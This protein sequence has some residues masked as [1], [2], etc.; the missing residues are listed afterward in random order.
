MNFETTETSALLE[1]RTAIGE[2]LNNEGADL[3]ALEAE[4]RAINDELEKRR[5]TADKKA[6]IRKAVAAGEGE[7]IM[8]EEKSKMEN[9]EIRN[10]PAYI[11]AYANYIKTGKDAECRA[12]LSTN[13]TDVSASLTGYVPVPD[14]VDP[15]IRTAWEKSGVMAL[16]TTTNLKGNVKVGFELSADGAVVHK[17]GTSAPSEEVITLGIVNMVPQSIKKWITVSDEALDLSGAD[18][19][20][21]IY[22]E[23]TYRIAKKAEEELIGIIAALPDTATSSSVSAAT[24]SG[25]PALTTISAA[26]GQVVG[27]N[28]TVV[29]NR[30]SWAKFK[31]AQYA[32]NFSIDIFEGL[33]VVFSDALPSYDKAV[34]DD[35]G[36]VYAIVG[37]FREGAQANYPNGQGIG[38]KVDDT[39]LAEKD[40]VKFVGRMFV[41]LGAVADKRFCLLTAPTTP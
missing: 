12:L 24:I 4:V 40:L 6:E 33:P 25:A 11:D 35:D 8:K 5:N 7:I 29:M 27:T 13:G 18:F 21:Y 16:V 22:S 17:E 38:I 26:M 28:L 39:S 19:L 14:L 30:A 23:L 2:E 9:V 15:I 34:D 20:N 1:R 41:G 37:D 31:A 36:D 32:A 10:T 3:D